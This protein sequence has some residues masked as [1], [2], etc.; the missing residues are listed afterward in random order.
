MI[1]LVRWLTGQEIVE[2]TANGGQFVY[3]ET[4]SWDTVQAMGTTNEGA[5]G[6]LNMVSTMNWDFPFVMVDLVGTEGVIR[7]EHDRYSY[8]MQN[9]EYAHG[10][11]LMDH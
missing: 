3:P 6:Q 5:L 4:N 9:P 11:I 7:T 2:L 10:P 8:V 1:D